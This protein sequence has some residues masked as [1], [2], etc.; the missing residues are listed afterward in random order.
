MWS[1]YER[2]DVAR[3]VPKLPQS[4]LSKYETWKTIVETQ[5]PEALRKLPGLHDEALRGEWAGHRSSRLSLQW[6]VI[7]KIERDTVRVHV[8]R[9]TPHD[10]R[11]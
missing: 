9:I 1:I 2:K 8:E 3:V 5:G 7:Y 6:R 4:V 11:K 10:Y